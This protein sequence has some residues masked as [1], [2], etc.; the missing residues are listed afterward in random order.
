MGLGIGFPIR[1]GRPAVQISA[2]SG[3]TFLLRDDFTTPASAPLTSPRTAEPGPGSWIKSDS[4]NNLSVVGG[5]LV[6]AAKVADN[7]PNLQSV[8]QFAR[9]VGRAFVAKVTDN[10]HRQ[11]LGFYTTAELTNVSQAAIFDLPSV[12][13]GT[14]YIDDAFAL[15]SGTVY[16]IAIVLR[17][18]GAFYFVKGG[19]YTN[20]T[21][22]WVDA[23]VTTATMTAGLSVVAPATLLNVDFARVRDLSFPFN[24]DYG[25]A[26]QRLAGAQSAGV[27]FTHEAN[28][29]IEWTQ[30]TRPS[31]SITQVWFRQQDATNYWEAQITASGELSLYEV[32]AAS[33]TQRAAAAGV[34]TNGHRCVIIC[35]GTTIRGYSNNVLRWTYSSASNFATETDG[36]LN[37]LGTGGAVSDIV[38]WPRTIS[39]V[40]ATY[41]DAAV[42]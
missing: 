4:G 42:A 30:T 27:T 28:C 18:S 31:G 9:V 17:V 29:V 12:Y 15:S 41:L 24:D 23:S 35:D 1:I 13:V 36:R 20:W 34:V 37:A 8:T 21:L 25:L 5:A 26:T 32:V 19:A 38:S 40:A 22:G 10:A 33:Y 39:G 16:Q 11:R 14:T 6:S 3:P 7:D 2:P